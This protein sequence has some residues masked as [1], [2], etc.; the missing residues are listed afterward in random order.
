MSGPGEITSVIAPLPHVA[1]SVGRAFGQAEAASAQA[2]GR[3][4]QA[5]EHDQQKVARAQEA[6]SVTKADE[7]RRGQG[8]Q[9]HHKRSSE[10]TADAEDPGPAESS[11]PWTGRIINKTV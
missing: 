1:D 10:P 4:R 11:S 5:M 9:R 3:T 6:S 2:S 7:E 8:Q